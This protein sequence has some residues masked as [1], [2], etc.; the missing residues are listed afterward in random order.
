VGKDRP[1]LKI[2]AMTAIATFDFSG[3]AMADKCQTAPATEANPSESD[4]SVWANKPF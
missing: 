1:F 3:H 4:L 2:S